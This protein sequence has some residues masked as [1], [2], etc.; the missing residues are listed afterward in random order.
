MTVWCLILYSLIPD[1]ATVAHPLYQ[2]LK[3]DS[4][5]NWSIEC[6]IAFKKIKA[7]ILSSDFLVHFQKDLPV[8]LVVMH[9]VLV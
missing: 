2:L 3:N 6:Q 5:C 4:E 7:L 8:I 1:L 9:Q